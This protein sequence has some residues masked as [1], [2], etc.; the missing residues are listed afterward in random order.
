MR[1]PLKAIFAAV[2]LLFAQVA[3][4]ASTPAFTINSPSV[5]AG[6]PEVFTITRTAGS[7]KGIYV[8]FQT[9]DKTAI[10]GVDYAATK[11]LIYVKAGVTSVQVSVPTFVHTGIYGPLTFSAAVAANNIGATGIG[12]IISTQTAP[13]Q[14]CWDGSVIPTTQQCPVQVSSCKSLNQVDANHPLPQADMI[15]TAAKT[16]QDSDYLAFL[17]GQGP[18][19]GPVPTV[20]QGQQYFVVRGLIWNGDDTH[21]VVW[22][23]NGGNFTGFN[24]GAYFDRSC[25]D[26]GY[27][28]PLTL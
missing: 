27:K 20:T 5:Q 16:C 15:C 28:A 12:T 2:V 9:S 10:A 18:W 7:N 3:T 21:V 23:L 13:T 22:V 24:G 25:F 1:S 26:V 19:A 11:Q 17:A 8:L 6:L 4:A 14:T